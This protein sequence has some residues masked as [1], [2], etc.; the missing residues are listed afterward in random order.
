M[1]IS[2]LYE[3]DGASWAREGEETP[4]GEGVKGREPQQVEESKRRQTGT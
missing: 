1:G 4:K 3:K 2:L